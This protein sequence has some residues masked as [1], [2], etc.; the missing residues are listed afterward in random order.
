MYYAVFVP[1]VVLRLSCRPVGVSHRAAVRPAKPSIPVSIRHSKPHLRYNLGSLVSCGAIDCFVWYVWYSKQ[2]ISICVSRSMETA[3]TYL[4]NLSSLISMPCVLTHASITHASWRGRGCAHCQ[5]LVGGGAC[6]TPQIKSNHDLFSIPYKWLWYSTC[7]VEISFLG[8]PQIAHF[9]V[10]KLKSSLRWV[11][12]HPPP[13]ARSLRSF[14]KIAP[15]KY[16]GSLR[17]CK[18]VTCTLRF[19]RSGRPHTVRRS[20]RATFCWPVMHELK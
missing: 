8:M 5:V 20:L 19:S 11:G 6:P 1:I 17:H 12:G 13:P 3:T 18:S 15:P 10:E 7:E 16:F 14:A 2:S 9:Q 4:N